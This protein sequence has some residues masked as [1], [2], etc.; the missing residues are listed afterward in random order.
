M[1]V[2]FENI[3]YNPMKILSYATYLVVMMECIM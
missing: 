3:K 2:M 1:S